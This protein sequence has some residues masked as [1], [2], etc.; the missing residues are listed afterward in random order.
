MITPSEGTSDYRR[1]IDNTAAGAPQSA[2]ACPRKANT[3]ALAAMAVATE[4][5]RKDSQRKPDGDI[6]AASAPIAPV[7]SPGCELRC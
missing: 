3:T 2:L 4:R 5:T 1:V 6:G 7:R